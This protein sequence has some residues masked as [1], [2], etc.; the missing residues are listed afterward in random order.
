MY[1]TKFCRKCRESITIYEFNENNGLCEDCLE[2]EL[3]FKRNRDN[4]TKKS[5]S[6]SKKYDGEYGQLWD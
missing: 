6:F 2:I 1:D 3:A 4:E 5:K